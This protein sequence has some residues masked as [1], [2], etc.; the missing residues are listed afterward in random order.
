M[1]NRT[2]YG[3]YSP[4]EMDR[5]STWLTQNHVQFEI[6]RDDQQAKESLMNDG[7]NVVTLAEFRTQV[8]LAQ[9]FYVALLEPTE[10]LQKKF[11]ELFTLKPEVFPEQRPATVDDERL[12]QEGK[13]HKQAKKRKWARLLTL[14]YVVPI[15]FSIYYL[16]FKES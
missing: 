6:L 13:I 15:L 12:L 1:E 7:Q 4:Q 5:I 9:V 2:Q 14:L 11:E 8:Y 16:F 10:A 3:P